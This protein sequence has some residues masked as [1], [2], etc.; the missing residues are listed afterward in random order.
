VYQ[1]DRPHRRGRLTR[2]VPA[3]ALVASA[4]APA[5]AQAAHPFV[6]DDTG[7]QGAGN[8]QL[9]LLGQRDRARSSADPGGGPVEQNLRSTLVNPVLTYGITD[10]VDLALGL[11]YLRYSV[12]ENGAPAG[13]ASGMSDTTLELKWRFYEASGLSLALKP[14]LQFATGDADRGLGT[15]RTSWGVNFI[16]TWSAEPW[17]VMANAAWFRQRYDLPQDSAAYRSDLWR[18]SAG[19]TYAVSGAL[20]LGGELGVRTNPARDD[21]FAPGNVGQFAMVGAIWSPHDKLDLDAGYRR[22][23]NHAEVDNVFLIGATLRW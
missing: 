9:E 4:G 8:W 22:R 5:V 3:L 23:L 21:P 20:R 11:N 14:G 10:T 16:G 17:T 6:T 15:G 19:F 7:T 13:S 1:R 2:A 12:S 18:V